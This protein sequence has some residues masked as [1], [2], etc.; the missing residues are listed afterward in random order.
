[1]KPS[2]LRLDP[3][4]YP[5]TRQ[6]PIR[7]NDLNAGRHVSNVAIAGIYDDARFELLLALRGDEIYDDVLSSVIVEARLT[8]LKTIF[9]PAMAIIGTGVAR[10][11]RSSFTV[12]QALFVDGVCMGLCDTIYVQVGP[13]G[14]CPIPDFLRARFEPLMCRIAPVDQDDLI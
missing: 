7:F 4:T 9:Y 8:Y 5:L 1:M 14:A 12:F 13:E 2:P 6:V 11:G 3:A 10:L